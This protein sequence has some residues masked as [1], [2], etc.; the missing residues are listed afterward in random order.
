[1]NCA[2]C[3]DPLNASDAFQGIGESV[4]C[5]ACLQSMAGTIKPLTADERRRLKEEVKKE[6][7]GILPA[8]SIRSITEEG[9]DRILKSSSKTAYEE[10]ISRFV[11]EVQRIAARAL[12]AHILQV[13]EAM[14]GGLLEQEEIVRRDLKKIGGL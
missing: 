2:G 9:L 11:N 1:M 8:S 3:N 5:L 4:L 7:E 13:I 6:M 14:R 10:E 12:G